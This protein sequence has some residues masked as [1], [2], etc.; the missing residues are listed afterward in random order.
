MQSPRKIKEEITPGTLRVGTTY[1]YAR[2]YAS[3]PA[4]IDGLPNFF[5]Q[6]VSAGLTLP[7]LERGI[8]QLRAVDATDGIRRP[9]ILISSSPHKEGSNFTP[10]QDTFEPDL[11]FVRYFG[12]NKSPTSPPATAPGNAV[13]LG[14]FQRHTSPSRAER[15]LA[16]PLILF[17]RVEVEGRRKGN[18]QFA[19][20]AIIERT[21]LVT[22]FNPATGKYFTNYVFEFAVLSLAREN[23]VLNWSWLSARRNPAI[24]VDAT[25]KLAPLTWQEWLKFGNDALPRLRRHVAR[26]SVVS[27]SSQKPTL[28]SR[29]HAC[30]AQIY[31]HYTHK[32]HHFEALAS[33][34]AAHVLSKSGA[35][36]REGWITPGS[37]DHGTDFVGRLTL[38]GGFASVKLVVLGQAKCESLNSATGGV[39]IAR[40]VARLRRGW[41]GVYVTT[42]Y[43]SEPVQKEVFEDQYPIILIHGL[44]VAQAAQQLAIESGFKDFEMYLAE[45]DE[46]YERMISHRRPE[47]ILFD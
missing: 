14:E 20:L 9:V 3:T 28:G 6:T 4:E 30:L 27:T 37:G 43:F 42:S 35:V 45:L 19:G 22:Q 15:M 33:A 40:T 47:E 11:G 12:D 39:H 17:R 32:K 44:E 8:T 26:V 41:V 29:E 36:Y 21:E 1:R 13:L 31:S 38:G 10:W 24:D 46:Y 34:I 2:P 18:V 5:A 23:E 16:T 25:V 7:T